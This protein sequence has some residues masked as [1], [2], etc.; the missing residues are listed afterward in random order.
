[1]D[2]F[3]DL[4]AGPPGR[5]RGLMRLAAVGATLWFGY[6]GIRG[7]SDYSDWWRYG[8]SP[9][10]Y[11][12][13]STAQYNYYRDWM[14]ALGVPIVLAGIAFVTRWVWQG[15]FERSGDGRNGL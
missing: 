10:D 8:Q 13:A 7:L 6:W 12:M 2:K 9:V 1:M 14:M 11:D 5:R 3:F 15:F 4:F